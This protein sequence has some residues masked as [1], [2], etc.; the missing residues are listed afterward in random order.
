MAI[1]VIVFH[2]HDRQ[3]PVIRVIILHDRDRQLAINLISK[4]ETDRHVAIKIIL[5]KKLSK[6]T[7]RGSGEGLSVLFLA[8]FLISKSL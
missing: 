4:V 8:F 2:G 7:G 1:R 5:L 6:I 3:L